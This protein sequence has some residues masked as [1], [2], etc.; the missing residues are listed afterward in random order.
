MDWKL[1]VELEAVEKGFWDIGL[2]TMS[3]WC[4]G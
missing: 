2:E 1:E 4:L 3:R